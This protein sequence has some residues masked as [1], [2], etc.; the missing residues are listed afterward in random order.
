MKQIITTA[1]NEQKARRNILANR[2]GRMFVFGEKCNVLAFRL[3]R[4]RFLP[5]KKMKS[6][7]SQRAEIH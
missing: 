5:A 2:K 7:L 3:A 1:I 6:G 4:T